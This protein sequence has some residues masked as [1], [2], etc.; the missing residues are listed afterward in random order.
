MPARSALMLRLITKVRG[1][2]RG[3][4]LGTVAFYGPDDRRATKLVVGI[5]PEGADDPDK[6]RTWVAE[7]GDIRDD[8][9]V[10]SEALACLEEHGVLSVEMRR[11]IVGCPHEQAPDCSTG[12]A[13]PLCPFW[14]EH[15]RDGP[16]TQ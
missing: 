2:F 13:C 11:G 5:F 16:T 9:A 8:G 6:M 12:E 7:H 4:P 1:G 3:Y 10:L 14:R 15:D